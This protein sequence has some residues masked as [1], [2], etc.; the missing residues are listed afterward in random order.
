MGEWAAANESLFS[1]FVF[2]NCGKT[3]AYDFANGQ[4]VTLDDGRL[5]DEPAFYKKRLFNLNLGLGGPANDEFANQSPTYFIEEF[6]WEMG[7]VKIKTH[8]CGPSF[9]HPPKTEH[10]MRLYAGNGYLMV[11]AKLPS[12]GVSKR[13]GKKLAWLYDLSTSLWSI[14][15]RPLLSVGRRTYD[16]VNNSGGVFTVELPGGRKLHSNCDATYHVDLM[17]E[18]QW[19]AV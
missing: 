17:F 11:Y 10:F 14:I 19:A 4:L 6:H 1:N 5:F 12:S 9:E 13:F 8:R 3:M 15:N 2:Q 7:W 16:P 18:P